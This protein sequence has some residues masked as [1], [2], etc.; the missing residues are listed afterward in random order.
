MKEVYGNAWELAKDYDVLCITTNG[1]VKKDGECV[2]GRGIAAQFK[3]RYPFGPKILGDKIRENGN[4]VQAIMWNDE[5]TY[6]AFPT[7]HFWYENS[8]IELI[9]RSASSLALK[10]RAMPERKFLLP[11]PGC[12]NGKLEWKDVKPVIENILPDNVYIVSY[13]ESLDI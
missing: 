11:R 1:M 5:I 7:K 6:M 13:Q 2:M 8:D 12:S 3:A 10:A 4:I 9:E